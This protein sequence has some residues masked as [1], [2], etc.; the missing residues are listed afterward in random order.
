M[1]MARHCQN[2]EQVCLPD[3]SLLYFLLSFMWW[4]KI[5]C[6]PNRLFKINLYHKALGHS[7]AK[8]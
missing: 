3:K 1:D 4:Y 8:K 6:I 7:V 2:S 5:P